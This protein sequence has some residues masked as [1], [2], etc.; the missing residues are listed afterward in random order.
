MVQP[1]RQWSERAAFRGAM[2]I[3]DRYQVGTMVC[4]RDKDMKGGWCLASN[5]LDAKASDVTKLYG[6]RRGIECGF[7][8]TKDPRFGMGMGSIHVKSAA[9]R[10]RL[11]LLN[12]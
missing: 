9:R 12:A 5:Y 6:E 4:V 7:R 8:D 11:W 3:A 2:V 1:D 10:D